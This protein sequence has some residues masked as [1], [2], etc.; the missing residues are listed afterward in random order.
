M[1][2]LATHLMVRVPKP[3]GNSD[4]VSREQP[5]RAVTAEAERLPLAARHFRITDLQ[6]WMDL[7]A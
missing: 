6:Q 5:V 2:D 3:E 7:C 4:G 1:S